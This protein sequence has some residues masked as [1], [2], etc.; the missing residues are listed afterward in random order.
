MSA[1]TPETLDRSQTY[2]LL[3]SRRAGVSEEHAVHRECAVVHG[4]VL[5]RVT[6]RATHGLQLVH[7]VQADSGGQG[8]H[9]LCAEL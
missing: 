8:A 7:L 9:L 3:V 5:P 2:L 4:L 6:Q 1:N